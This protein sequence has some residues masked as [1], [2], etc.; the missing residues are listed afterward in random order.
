MT[1]RS[2]VGALLA[3][4]VLIVVFFWKLALSNLIMAGVDVF[5][6]FYPYR[7]VVND[8]LAH[9]RLPLWNPNLFMGVPLLSNGQAGVLYPLN[10]LWVGLPAPQAINYSIVLHVWLGGAFFYLFARTSLRLTPVSAWL[11]ASV[12]AL[13]GYVGSLVEHVNQLQALAWLPLMVWCVD[14]ARGERRTAYVLVGALALALQILAGH[15]QVTYISLAGLVVWALCQA[16]AAA[17]ARRLDR[18]AVA[19]LARAA[20]RRLLP[21][22]VMVALGVG[23]SAVQL[24]PMLE[25]SRLSIRGGGLS[26]RE[27]VAFSLPITQLLPALLPTFG[28][29]EPM[30]SEYI[31]FMGVAALIAVLAGLKRARRYP[32]LAALLV[33]GLALALGVYNPLTYVLYRLAPGYSLFRVPARWLALYTFAAAAFAAIGIS[34]AGE[35]T[36]ASENKEQMTHRRRAARVLFSLAAF[37]AAIIYAGVSVTPMIPVPVFWLVIALLAV[38]LMSRSWPRSSI[39]RWSGTSAMASLV[40]IVLFVATRWLPYNEPT[41]PEAFSFVRNSIAFLWSAPR[42]QPSRILSYSDLGW[43]PGDLTDIRAMLGGEIPP[44]AVYEYIVAAKTKEIVAPN[45]A[46]LYHLDSVDGYD[47]GVLPLARYVNLQSLLLSEEQVNP[48]GRLRERLHAMPA[49]RWLDLFNVRYV[50]TDKIFDVWVDGVYYDLGLGLVLPAGKP[51]V[52]TLD[53]P[54]DYP[55]TGLGIISYLQGATSLTDGAPVAEIAATDAQGKSYRFIVRAGDDTA[56][57]EYDAAKPAHRRAR[58]VGAL[59]DH[60]N[61]FKYKTAFP[62]DHAA[63]LTHLTVRPL[64]DSGVWTLM[65]ASLV[66]ANSG[67]GRPLTFARD[68]RF[69]LVHSG[70]VKIYEHLDVAPRARVVHRAQ[71]QADD[72]LALAFM[73]SEGFDPRAEIVLAEGQVIRS[74][75]PPTAAHFE[76]YKPEHIRLT[77]DDAATGYL[78]IADTWYPGWR[79]WVDGQPAPIIRADT[80]F[81]AIYLPGGAHSVELRFEPESLRWGALITAGALTIWL[82]VAARMM[83]GRSRS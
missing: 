1:R 43:D 61:G 17:P 23:L 74:D 32:A 6:Y 11:G 16:I 14:L 75:A 46:M 35:I 39:R 60:P 66:D 25:L 42:D 45:L 72:A 24:V 9:G 33:V 49:A 63:T 83:W 73:A 79:A 2:D 20:A 64:L 21:L 36:Q 48:D 41:A 56:E 13:N 7:A 28:M 30:F 77:T 82:A 51:Q 22:A 29:G 67:T 55:A 3:L 27:V 71:V 69:K 59:R 57:S 18:Q 19:S 44:E 80:Y 26:F 78:L 8:A 37:G 52:Y 47:G 31:A 50:I 58:A 54:E 62:F 15:A 65:G 53:V 34:A 12:F 38:W 68:A 4:A 70:D 76:L 5:T 81:R 40:L 10:W